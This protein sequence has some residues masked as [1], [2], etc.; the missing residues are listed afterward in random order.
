M[1][2]IFVLHFIW[3]DGHIQTVKA[4]LYPFASA[5]EC[6]SHKDQVRNYIALWPGE[7][8]YTVTCEPAASRTTQN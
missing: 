5:Q 4:S 6:N 3:N 1:E 2:W 7:V 8:A